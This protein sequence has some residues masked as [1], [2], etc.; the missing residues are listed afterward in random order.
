MAWREAHAL[1]RNQVGEWVVGLGK[2][3]VNGL[4]NLCGGMRPS[5]GKNLGMG[6][7]NKVPLAKAARNNDLAVFFKCLA[8]GI[9]T[10]LHRLVNKAAGVDNH[11]VSTCIVCGNGVALSL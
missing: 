11:K 3:G 6:F 8:N 1:L 4:H 9:E 7:L 2:M 5:N 10:F